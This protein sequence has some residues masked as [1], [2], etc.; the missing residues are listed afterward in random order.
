M[1]LETLICSDASVRVLRLFRSIQILDIL[2]PSTQIKHGVSFN[3]THPLQSSVSLPI[4]GVSSLRLLGLSG[5]S[6]INS[7]SIRFLL[8]LRL[9]RWDL[10][11]I[12][13]TILRKLFISKRCTYDFETE[14]RS[15]RSLF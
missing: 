12:L 3:D 11:C 4:K 9:K 10:F 1:S 7:G 13:L 2:T 8:R 15:R 6:V 14:L 5:L